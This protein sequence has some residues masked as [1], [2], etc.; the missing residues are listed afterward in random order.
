D[1]GRHFVETSRRILDQV[2]EV[3]RATSGEY[4]TPRGKLSITAPISLGR[5]YVV[6]IIV[7]FRKT[8][9]E[10]DVRLVLSDG[11]LNHMDNDID[12]A[13]R[14]GHLSDSSLIAARVGLTRRIVCGS[15]AY[16]SDK[17]KPKKPGDLG[18][19]D[20]ITFEN[21]AS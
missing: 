20:C 7:E 6:P 18:R 17:G 14:I 5:L 10:I 1:A 4:T 11:V 16:F 15:P 3:E 9:P 12:V 21:M 8:F 2:E 13:V 19:H